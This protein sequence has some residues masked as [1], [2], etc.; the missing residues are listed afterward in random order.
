MRTQIRSSG[1]LAPAADVPGL[2]ATGDLRFSTD[3][4]PGISR[5]R[6]G[7]GFRY[8]G[9]HG[10]PIRHAATLAR[11]RA[12][13][14]PPAWRDVWICA[15]PRGHLQ[16]VGRDAR[17]RKQSRYHPA[18][19]ARR[20]EAKFSRLIA[21]GHALPRIRRH[22]DRDL[23]RPGLSKNKVLAT[24]VQLLESTA[25]RIG[26]KAYAR[27]NASFGLTTLRN[28]HVSGGS[29]AFRLRFRGKGGKIHDI[30]VH[31][32]RLARIVA[33]CGSL[34]GQELFQYLD[35]EDD[36]RPI[37]SSD[38]NAYLRDVAGTEVTAKDFRT[39]I[40]TLVAFHE[41]RSMPRPRAEAGSRATVTR[42]LD[43]VAAVL[44]NTTAVSRHSY[45][46]PAILDG[47][48]AGSLPRGRT[49]GVDRPEPAPF[50]FGRREELALIRFLE[51]AERR[52][53]RSA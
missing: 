21:F 43:A 6:T 36:P 10:A 41:L 31:D 49:R 9:P 1:R 33:R 30:G 26:N 11:L 48:L 47:Y 28:R 42:S 13:A 50:T 37:E 46:A 51:R 8:F 17:G 39:W 32:G 2:S 38:V 53:M 19:R 22:A 45:V 3:L 27:S 14:I 40:G 15:D 16:A 5:R 25:M 35:E 44:G 20:D 18:W 12:L 7:G 34:P 29:S 23:A 24:V 52:R 4:D